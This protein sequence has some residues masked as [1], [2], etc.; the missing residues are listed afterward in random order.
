MIELRVSE[1]DPI[2]LE[3]EE[4]DQASLAVL[5]AFVSG[6]DILGLYRVLQRDSHAVPADARNERKEDG[7]GCEGGSHSEPVHHP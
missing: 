3:A 7:E 1:P 5:E 6:G 4:Q 2:V